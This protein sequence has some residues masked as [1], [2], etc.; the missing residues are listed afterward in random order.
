MKTK[1]LVT[2]TNGHTG[3]PAAKELLSLG[4]EVR[5]LVRNL[6][7][8]KAQELKSLGAELFIGDMNDYRDI[9][10]AL[11]GIKRAY[12]CPPFGRNTLFQT[13]A[14]FIAAEESHE[15]EH[16]VY[17]SQ[18][19]LNQN[20]P[21]INTKMQWLGDQLVKKHKR[22]K[23]TFVNP[24]MFAFTYFFTVE[25]MAQLGIMPTAIQ[26]EGL[27]APPSEDDQ[28]RVVAHILKSPE[29]HHQKT[30]RPTGPKVISQQD[31]AKIFGKVLNKKIR[32][33]PISEK[34]LL[35]SLK[36]GNYPI[37]EYSNIRYY[38]KDVSED[39]FAINGTTNVVKELT[40]K[41]P[42]DFETIVRNY[43]S[44][45]PEVKQ[46]FKNKLKA[47]RNFAKILFTK[48]PDMAKFEAV[49]YYPNFINGMNQA[50]ENPDWLKLR[51]ENNYNVSYGKESRTNI[52]NEFADTEEIF[53]WTHQSGFD[54]LT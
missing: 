53:D 22:V 14:F 39:V 33:M 44:H 43:V 36:A 9:K 23:Y 52:Q 38:L 37:Y 48:A 4:F 29:K 8:P 45:M 10:K 7:N 34:M 32:L 1:I 28:G 21:A 49:Q 12:F 13:N 27:N 3:F 31:V 11:I 30:Y 40:G 25:F 35:K 16:V 24:G 20:H 2:A 47:T 19:L 51:Q 15:L 42:E 26:G 50:I 46:T 5:A 6:L 18:W 41:D 17:M 54:Q